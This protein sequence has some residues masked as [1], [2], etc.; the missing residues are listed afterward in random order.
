MV[1]IPKKTNQPISLKVNVIAWPEIRLN[2]YD[3]TD[4]YVN[5]YAIGVPHRVFWNENGQW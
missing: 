3:A 5:H 4:Q 2:Y 1:D